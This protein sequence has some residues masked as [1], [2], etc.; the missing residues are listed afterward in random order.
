MMKKRLFAVL[1]ALLCCG[2]AVL[3]VSAQVDYVRLTHE[4]IAIN[5]N[6]EYNPDTYLSGVLVRTDGT[7][8]TEEMLSGME[9]FEG[10][11][12]WESYSASVKAD[13]TPDTEL[14]PDGNG[15]MIFID[16]TTSLKAAGRLMQMEVA[17]ITDIML[18]HYMGCSPVDVF[19]A[20]TIQLTDENTDISS[21][22][23]FEGFAVSET[24]FVQDRTVIELVDAENAS[25][26]A[27]AETEQD[28]Y[29][30]MQNF[31]EE[32]MAANPGVFSEITP[33]YEVTEILCDYGF[34]ATPIWQTAGDH[35]ADG[36]VNSNDAADLLVQAAQDGVA[37]ASE[38][39]VSP[40]SDVNLDGVA[41]STDAAYILQYAA[42]KGSG[43]DADW[44][45][46]LKK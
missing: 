5:G 8:L 13:G 29:V 41:D 44:V 22:S 9:G 45:E 7:E 31:A 35:N 42:L 12:D 4:L 20:F 10:L 21:I 40:D 30:Y 46:I 3:P 43:A 2:S 19:P 26:A 36:E 33:Y 37:E 25:F 14:I 16:G 34:T 27:A 23:G 11:Q 1:T 32:V 24:F 18:V 38:T 28:L 17:C 15:Y 39:A 6:L